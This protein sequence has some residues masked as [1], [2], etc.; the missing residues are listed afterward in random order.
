MATPDTRAEVTLRLERT[1]AAPPEKVFEAWTR[2]DVMSRWFAPSAEYEAVV[3]ALEPRPGG[4]Y[5]VEMRHRGG[6]VHVVGGA[7][8]EV[9]PPERLVF[10]WAWEGRPEDGETQVTVTISKAGSGTK[11]VL[12]HEKLVSPASRDLHEQGWNGC[13]GRLPAAVEASPAN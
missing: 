12:L 4:R 2:P 5:R 11:L 8:R 6:N 13:L 1:I 9:R 10:S 7:F 3:T